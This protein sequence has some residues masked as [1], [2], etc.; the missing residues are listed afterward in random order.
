MNLIRKI[1]NEAT[2]V[3]FHIIP[4]MNVLE[5]EL[6]KKSI[7]EILSPHIIKLKKIE[8]PKFDLFGIEVHCLESKI[9]I[10]DSFSFNAY[11]TI[12]KDFNPTKHLTI[13]N[14]IP[15]NVDQAVSKDVVIDEYLAN[16]MH[17]MTHVLENYQREK[18]TKI[19]ITGA[20]GNMHSDFGSHI[21]NTNVPNS[22]RKFYFLMYASASLEISAR[23]AQVYPYIRNIKNVEE[24]I[25]KV[26]KTF[27][28]QVAEMLS[29]YSKD[30]LFTFNIIELL[31]NSGEILAQVIHANKETFKKF[32]KKANEFS[33]MS[34]TSD[35]PLIKKSK[36]NL[37]KTVN[38]YK[39][40]SKKDDDAFIDYWVKYFNKSGEK[41]K[42]KI[43]RLAHNTNL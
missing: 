14:L 24:R 26:K 6:N 41:A 3:S 25:E 9:N 12:E 31:Q 4:Y 13:I 32:E 5:E 19:N 43:M 29:T 27:P 15:I 34:L 22:I 20:R 42:K 16:F 35:S 21:L 33:L 30:E 2:G 7:D 38:Y 10:N 8:N 40:L 1:L 28:W 39:T 11:I 17:E 23:T 36:Q 37:I 18:N